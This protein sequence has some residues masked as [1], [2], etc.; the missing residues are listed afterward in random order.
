MATLFIGLSGLANSRVL[1]VDSA[2]LTD[3][4]ELTY[5]KTLVTGKA[6]TAVVEIAYCGTMY[7]D[8]LKTLEHEFGQPR[9]V[10]SALRAI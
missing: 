10:V 7:R 1:A 2:A 5:L 9:A 8:A 3:D 4:K 6:K